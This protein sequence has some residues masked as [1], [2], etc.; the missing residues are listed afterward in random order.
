MLRVFENHKP[1]IDPD[2]YIDDAAMLIGDVEVGAESSIWPMCVVRGDI[3]SIR[4]GR[5]SNIQDGSILHV[6]HDSEYKPGGSPLIIGDDVTVGHQVTL[7]GCTIGHG[8]LI[9]MGSVVLDDAVVE[10]GAMIGA[11][12][13]VN[14]GKVI[15]GGY[16]WLGSPVRRVRELTDKEKSYLQYSAGHYVR[17]AARHRDSSQSV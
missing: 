15:E 16:L 10:D 14:P 9:G 8:C 3:H 17:L 2:A 5:R 13:L 11:G 4:I 1:V 12:A 6:S 7:H